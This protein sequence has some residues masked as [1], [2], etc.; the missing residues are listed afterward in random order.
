MIRRHPFLVFII[1]I[2]VAVFIL[3]QFIQSQ[4]FAGFVS[5]VISVYLPKDAGVQ[6]AFKTVEVQFFPPAIGV[7]D[8]DLNFINK[9]GR[10]LP[11][12]KIRAKE[13]SF[14]FLPFQILRGDI[15]VNELA[16]RGAELDVL[17]LDTASTT[18]RKPGE[19]TLRWD[20]LLQIRAESIALLDSKV[21]ISLYSDSIGTKK[22]T[23]AGQGPLSAKPF[24]AFSGE[25]RAFQVSQWMG[26][27]GLGYAVDV[28]LQGLQMS[29]AQKL[30]LNGSLVQ[31][32]GMLNSGDTVSWQ[33]P[34]LRTK[35]KVNAVRTEV[36]Q[37]QARLP[38]FD[39]DA[40]ATL[41]GNIL[42]F[43]DSSITASIQTSMDWKLVS[44]RLGG[45]LFSGVPK[46]VLPKQGR[47]GLTLDLSLNPSNPISSLK[48]NFAMNATDLSAPHLVIDRVIASGE[49]RGTGN[50]GTSG[51]SP[52][53]NFAE[54][55]GKV[56]LD[57]KTA[58]IE[59]APLERQSLR[60]FGGG[61]RLEV[62]PFKSQL[63]NFALTPIELQLKDAHIQWLAAPGARTIFPLNFRTTGK[64][65][66][67]RLPDL[68]DF[69]FEVKIPDL[70][71]DRLVLDN[72]KYEINKPRTRIL[73][74]PRIRLQL[75]AELDADGFDEIQATLRLDRSRARVTGS[76]DFT[77]GLD[78]SAEGNFD[79]ADIGILAESPIQGAGSIGAKVHGPF[80]AV[81]LDFD[82]VLEGAK[83]LNINLDRVRGRVTYDDR[84]GIVYLRKVSSQIKNSKFLIDGLIDLKGDTHQ[85][86]GIQ[87]QNADVHDLLYAFKDIAA[88]LWWY[89]ETLKGSVGGEAKISGPVD[90]AQMS[91]SGLLYGNHWDYF[92]EKFDVVRAQG[93]YDRGKYYISNF[94]ATKK[95]GKLGGRVSYVNR[96]DEAG[97]LDWDV[98]TDQLTLSDL[99]LLANLDV[100]MRGKL[101]ARSTG[102]GKLGSVNSKTQVD[103]T[104]L[105]VRGVP[106]EESWLE[107]K[108]TQGDI[109]WR[110]RGLGNHAQ[111]EG[112]YSSEG[113]KPSQLRLLLED[114]DFSPVVLLLN[115]KLISDLDLEARVGGELKIQFDADA[116]D[117]GTGEMTFDKFF[118]RK[119]GATIEL[120]EPQRVPIRKGSFLIEQ[121]TLKSKGLEATLDLEGQEGRLKGNIYGEVDASV[122]EFLTPV[123][124]EAQGPIQLG[125]NLGG[126]LRQP[127]L[128]GSVK[129]SGGYARVQGLDSPIEAIRGEARLN[130]GVI[131][132]E[133]GAAELAGGKVSG[134]G[135]IEIFPNRYPEVDLQASVTGSRVKVYPFQYIKVS[136]TLGVKGKRLPYLIDGDLRSDSG[137]I[138]EKFSGS[139]SSVGSVKAARFYPLRSED[140][141]YTQSK[142]KLNIRATASHGILIQNDLFDAEGRG[143]VKI[144]NTLNAPRIIGNAEIIQGK[145]MFRDRDFVIQSGAAIF[146]NPT[147]FNPKFNLTAN[148]ELGTSKVQLYVSGNLENM[149]IDLSSNPAMTQ[150]EI[151]SLLLQGGNNVEGRKFTGSERS[152]FEAGDIASV[153]LHQWDVARDIKAKTGF[154][155]DIDESVNSKLG[156]SVLRGGAG[157]YQGPK[158]SVRRKIGKKLQL[159]GRTSVG[160]G[161]QE[162][163]FQ[164]DLQVTPNFSVIGVMDNLG[165]VSQSVNPFSFGFDLKLQ[166]K[167]K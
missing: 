161:A 101:S 69:R 127:L 25:V 87:V 138:I 56:E 152:T 151:F 50:G 140:E 88:P 70:F 120:A 144:V 9:K 113:K 81:V 158:L 67:R 84:V 38:L 99:D 95:G 27:G 137:L 16:V 122:S 63:K 82:P 98:K 66:L 18:K 17:V 71:I 42:V 93:G 39:V 24:F 13:V 132:I 7:S 36:D 3:I 112:V 68:G 106:M 28:W 75:E 10:I 150:S 41:T 163:T 114:C 26:K 32:L 44:D 162:Q 78:L 57:L 109:V 118:L 2:S 29:T 147:T 79:L 159:S 94:R 4:R 104:S 6:F 139:S 108:A 61:G 33:I 123:V 145:L 149:K 129:V 19:L 54:K 134:H 53:G 72:Q 45:S 153:V 126:T 131:R 141:D 77:E 51:E 155:F 58:I 80:S 34:E 128:E 89:P 148:T 46:S 130:Q 73:D 85:A 160:G 146:D 12:S 40:K 110:G 97:S 100:P 62:L 31:V 121:L 142:F 111:T 165:G 167:F 21:K 35:G 11:G 92:G 117:L 156:N 55:L 83:Y 8:L 157:A 136:G 91:I 30:P 103:L 124:H 133:N 37:F 60:R 65:S 22:S 76:I 125:L 64:V 15:R 143:D 14:V 49:L 135:Q 86:I 48:A 52:S 1:S 102:M 166:R 115:P 5:R 90:Y 59:S 43:E 96:G 23:A 164:A 20:E 74:V 116:I 107:V 119:R 47:S 105:V 154:E